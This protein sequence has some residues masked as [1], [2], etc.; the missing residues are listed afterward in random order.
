M[1]LGELYGSDKFVWSA[2][3]DSLGDDF[4]KIAPEF[5]NGEK[6]IDIKFVINDVE[7]PLQPF[8][9]GLLNRLQEASDWKAKNMVEKKAEPLLTMLKNL[10]ARIEENIEELYPEN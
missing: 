9:D 3:V 5:V 4:T 8:F 10:T 6:E 1:N 7:Y 2:I